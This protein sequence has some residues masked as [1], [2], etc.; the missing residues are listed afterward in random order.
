MSVLNQLSE[1]QRELIVQKTQWNE[2]GKFY[3]RSTE[4]ILTA[5]KPLLE[6]H[7][8]LLICTEEMVE[9]AG[10]PYVKVTAH[11]EYKGSAGSI[12]ACAHTRDGLT[13]GGM[14]APMVTN[15]ASSFAK[16]Q[17]LQHLFSIDDGSQPVPSKEEMDEREAETQAVA[18][19]QKEMDEQ[20][21]DDFVSECIK[22]FQA[23]DE[24]AVLKKVYGATYR[25][26]KKQFSQAVL[27]RIEGLYRNKLSMI[28]ENK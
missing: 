18:E 4:D 7:E 11:M 9:I 13:Q 22:S 10:Y 2:F 3:F 19:Q 12:E 5:L 8:C 26:A 6:K 15:S 16:K 14:M 25:E 17:A 20:R 27:L 21:I 23:C 28:K 1:I 24:E